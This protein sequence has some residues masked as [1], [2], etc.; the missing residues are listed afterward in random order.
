MLLLGMTISGMILRSAL[1][2]HISA[3]PRFIPAEQENGRRYCHPPNVTILQLYQ[4]YYDDS[5]EDTNHSAVDDAII[6]D[7]SQMEE[8]DFQVGV[9]VYYENYRIPYPSL[10]INIFN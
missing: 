6:Y 5:D 10:T 2:S 4:E 7:F 9:L 3:D 8:M 1:P